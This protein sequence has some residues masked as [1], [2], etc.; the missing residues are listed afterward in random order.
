MA[1]EIDLGTSTFS[2]L[3][4]NLNLT[5]YATALILPPQQT[6]GSMETT[7]LREQFQRGELWVD[8]A[9]ELKIHVCISV[10]PGH[11]CPASTF[12]SQIGEIFC[13]SK[14]PITNTNHYF[15][16]FTDSGI[17]LVGFR[18]QRSFQKLQSCPR[19]G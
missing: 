4:P 2:S 12:F 14:V 1:F 13:R 16:V 18:P 3:R 6:S 15:E 10:G 5:Q 19:A 8:Q 9:P 17:A 11:A 7:E